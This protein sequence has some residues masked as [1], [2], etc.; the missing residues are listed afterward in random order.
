VA[1]SILASKL[2]AHKT[3]ARINNYEYLLPKNKELFEKMGI[4]SMIYPEMLAAKEIVTA[5]RRPWTRQYW[6]LFGGA[7]ILIGVKVRDNSRLVNKHLSELLNEQKLYHIVAI[8]RQNET[9]IPRGTDR[10]ESGDIVFFTT[11]KS[12]IEDVRLHAG[13]RDPEVKKVII[14]GGSRIAIRT[15]QYLPNNIRV[16]VI[17]T[18]KEKSHRIAEVVPGNVLIINGDGRDTDLLMQEGIKD[19]QAFIALTDNSSTNILACLAAKR[20]GV[21][22]TIA[23]IENIDYIPLAESMDIGSVINKKLIAASHI[24]QF[25][26][27]ADVSNVKCLTFANADVAELVARPD[28]KITRKQVKDLNLP[29]DLTLGG[30]IRDGEPMMIKGDTHIQAYDHVV[31]FCLDTAMRKLED[32]FN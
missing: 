31:V 21:F 19:A 18:N 6:E 24:Y 28:S 17:E 25:L 29:K 1:A 9:I 3:L 12:H 13:K 26:L 20:A 27:D 11:T 8:K 30:L 5:V 10:I 15:C 23:K 32:Y 7:L 22:K 16:K 4:D 14:M 2:G